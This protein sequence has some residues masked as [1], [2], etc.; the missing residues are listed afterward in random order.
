[1]I[2][3]TG[4]PALAAIVVALV[5]VA[6]YWYWSP[7]LALR[8]MQSGQ[9][10]GQGPAP[11]AAPAGAPLASG[12]QD[13]APKWDWMRVGPDKLVAYQQNDSGGKKLALVFERS[14]RWRRRWRAWG[15]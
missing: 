9:F 14:G 7:L 4:K 2:R 1:M 3:R 10:G 5:A 6:A 15:R 8:A 11:A 12:K 13:G